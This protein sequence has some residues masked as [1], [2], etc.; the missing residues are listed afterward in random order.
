MVTNVTQRFGHMVHAV[1]AVALLASL[2]LVTSAQADVFGDF[3]YPMITSAYA[4]GSNLFIVGKD[5][6]VSSPP[7]VR[8]GSFTLIPSSYTAT[9]IVAPLPS[10]ITPGSYALWVQTSIRDDSGQWTFF[11]VTLG[12]SGSQGPKG[13]PGPQGPA[14]P[15]GAIGPAGPAGATGAAGAAGP[16]GPA[17]A[18]GDPGPQGAI[19]PAGADGVGVTLNALPGGLG[20]VCPAAGIEVVSPLSGTFAICNGKAGRDGAGGGSGS[21]AYQFSL[22]DE[23]GIGRLA[24]PTVWP[25]ALPRGNWVVSAKALATGDA[26]VDCKLMTHS[27]TI[28]SAEIDDVEVRP[29]AGPVALALLGTALT[30]D[31]VTGV[32]L[33]CGSTDPAFLGRIQLVA[34][35]VT[36]VLN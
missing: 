28:P 26:F 8:L 19:G 36:A 10:S 14:G 4:D 33:A 24:N 2:V 29:V 7:K 34:M 20:Q 17:G 23:T 21:V 35:Q 15:Q 11:A 1:C 12:D 27:D 32:D 30:D 18:K 9:T 3:D 6:G 31:N 13:D 22:R 25:L 16:A 5:F